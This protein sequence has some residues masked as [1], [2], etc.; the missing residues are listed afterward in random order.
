[1]EKAMHNSALKALRRPAINNTLNLSSMVS[2]WIGHKEPFLL[3]LINITQNWEGEGNSG[4]YCAKKIFQ[5][6]KRATLPSA[7]SMV[8]TGDYHKWQ[9]SVTCLLNE[10]DSV[11]FKMKT[12]FFLLIRSLLN[13]LN[14]IKLVCPWRKSQAGP[15]AFSALLRYYQAHSQMQKNPDRW[16][17]KASISHSI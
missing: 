11:G 7:L 14:Q 16:N 4:K 10:L 9:L 3:R 6:K 5:I 1:M 2:K 13:L 12:M 8:P 17:I 15:R